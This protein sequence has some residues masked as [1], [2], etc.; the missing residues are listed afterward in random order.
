MH[1]RLTFRRCILDDPLTPQK[2][3]L[4]LGK[5]YFEKQIILKFQD[6]KIASIYYLPLSE[7]GI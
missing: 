2:N 6:L 1:C 4:S 7:S 5:I 3:S